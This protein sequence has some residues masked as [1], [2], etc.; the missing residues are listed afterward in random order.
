MCKVRH[1]KKNRVFV[2]WRPQ[3]I[4]DRNSMIPRVVD[5]LRLGEGAS[6]LD[7]ERML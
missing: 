7:L 2:L 4:E 1:Y 3:N 5:K 6:D